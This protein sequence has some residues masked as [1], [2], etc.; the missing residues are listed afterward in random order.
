MTI[1]CSDLARLAINQSQVTLWA[2]IPQLVGRE[3]VLLVVFLIKAILE[4]LNASVRVL[5][6]FPFSSHARNADAQAISDTWRIS[7]YSY[8]ILLLN[9]VGFQHDY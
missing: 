2:N 7:S 8:L 6:S 1:L 5:C 3:D 9:N 4:T